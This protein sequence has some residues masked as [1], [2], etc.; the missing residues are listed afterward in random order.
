MSLCTT[1]Q[2]TFLVKI[3]SKRESVMKIKEIINNILMLLLV[4]QETL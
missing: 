1:Q 4:I 3:L 2:G